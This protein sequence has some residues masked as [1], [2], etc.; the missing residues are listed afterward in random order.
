VGLGKGDGEAEGK[1][2]R[3][4][5]TTK[6]D[7]QN[8]YENGSRKREEG[9]RKAKGSKLQVLDWVWQQREKCLAGGLKK[10]LLNKGGGV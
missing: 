7:G 8:E 10:L 5:F 1:H 9:G 6:E 3:V 4:G 2:S